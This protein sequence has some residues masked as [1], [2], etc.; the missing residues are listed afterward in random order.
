MA[1]RA[2]VGAAHRRGLGM[3][4]G[5]RG[6]ADLQQQGAQGPSHGSRAW[7]EALGVPYAV[8]WGWL[9]ATWRRRGMG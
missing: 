2:P 8:G 4:R 9:P 3:S 6:Q 1:G 7:R 5:E